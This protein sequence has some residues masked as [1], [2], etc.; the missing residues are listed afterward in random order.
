MRDAPFRLDLGVALFLL[1][2]AM[3]LAPKLATLA[4]VLA[5]RDLRRAYGGTPRIVASAFLEFVLSILIAPVCAVAVTFFML[6]LPFGRRVG[7]NAQQ[8]D[9]EGL[10]LS[11]AA[12][13]L[14]PQT[15]LGIVLTAWCWH[16]APG[17]VWYWAPLFAGA[18]GRDTARHAYG[19]SAGG[20]RAGRGGHVPYPRGA[21]AADMAGARASIQPVAQR[22]RRR[23][24]N[25]ARRARGPGVPRGV[26][27][28]D[29]ASRAAV[30]VDFVNAS[31]RPA[32]PKKTTST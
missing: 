13:R 30:A 8:R 9:A 4:D 7:W 19:A 23:R 26:W 3:S 17:A 5:R 32:A 6:G 28:A 2:L 21:R 27:L 25:E 22:R 1:M 31:R 16:V 14:W 29:T 11:A 12:R 10:P 18:R 24:P 15:M 20:P